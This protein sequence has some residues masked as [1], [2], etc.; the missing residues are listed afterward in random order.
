MTP[1]VIC[2][3][4]LQ[5]LL[6]RGG[7]FPSVEIETTIFSNLQGLV[8][9]APHHTLIIDLEQRVDRL[10]QT[11]I[12]LKVR[13]SI[14]IRFLWLALWRGNFCKASHI[15]NTINLVLTHAHVPP[16]LLILWR[17]MEGNLAWCM[18]RHQ[19]ATDKIH[20]GL[21]IS[22][23]AG[24]PLLDCML[25]CTGVN[26]ALAAGDVISARSYLHQAETS[27]DSESK[28]MVAELHR[29]R[30]GVQFLQRDSRAAL[31]S[32]KEALRLHNET[33]A[34]FLIAAT[35]LCVAQALVE[36]DDMEGGRYH[37]DLL[38]QH[39]GIL[40]SPILAHQALLVEAY[41]RIKVAKNPRH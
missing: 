35:R 31:E 12:K 17:I 18:A 25:W 32:A 23:H 41:S 21:D 3:E 38:V 40:K 36:T 1:V 16:I 28:L 27:I 7:G 11:D 30:S 2:A 8:F 29:L 24:L 9:A 14:G 22:R 34:P 13:V 15:V 37:L 10:F 5:Q 19:L 33:S 20:E 26:N 6:A 4:K 39:A